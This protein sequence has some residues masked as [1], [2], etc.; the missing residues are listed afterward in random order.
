[1]KFSWARARAVF[2]K[3]FL[4]LRK[5]RGLLWSMFAL[6]AILVVVPAGVVWAY[7][8]NPDDPN[9]KLM[10]RYY[11]AMVPGEDAARFIVDKVLVDWFSVYLIMPVFVPILIS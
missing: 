8:R 3:D 1:M 10:A 4:D 11:D 2:W 6:P 9:L 5:N 7:A